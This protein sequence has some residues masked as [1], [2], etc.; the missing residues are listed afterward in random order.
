MQSLDRVQRRP[1]SERGKRVQRGKI[2]EL[3]RG[4]LG[5]AFLQ[6]GGEP[7]GSGRIARER[8]R[9]RRGIFH[10]A[11]FSKL[12]RCPSALL[13]RCRIPEMRF[14]HGL[15][16]L[17]DRGSFAI[18]GLLRQRDRA[19]PHGSRLPHSTGTGE[20]QGL[21]VRHPVLRLLSASARDFAVHSRLVS[22]EKRQ[23]VTGDQKFR[24]FQFALR[25][26]PQD[27]RGLREPVQ[28]KVMW[29]HN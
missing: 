4:I 1:M 27:I 5:E 15:R 25:R 29:A 12:E 7:L 22:L 8:Q 16:G 20:H 14:A 26:P 17:V 6:V 10:I 24:D 18:A 23:V 13:R 19:L 3:H 9:K 2:L 28:K 11:A 21:I